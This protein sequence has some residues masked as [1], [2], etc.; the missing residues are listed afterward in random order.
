MTYKGIVTALVTPMKEDGSLDEKGFRNL[1]QFQMNKNIDGILIL[2]GTGEYLALSDTQRRRAIAIAVNEVD[3][4]VPLYVGLLSPGIN[5]NIQIGKYAKDAGVDAVMVITPYYLS[6]TQEGMMDYYRQI[7]QA[8]DM[9][10]LLYNYP[11]KTGVNIAPETVEKL[12]DEIPNMIGI[13]ECTYHTGHVID[14]IKRVGSKITVFAGEEYSALPTMILGA[15]GAI[16]ASS[17]IIPEFWLKLQ[18][19]VENKQIDEAV[20]LNEQYYSVFKA[21]F[22]ESNPGPLKYAL[23]KMHLIDQAVG[24]PLLNVSDETKAHMDQVMREF[25]I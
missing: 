23:H 16:M 21:I 20:K 14:L 17:N 25:G 3:G 9:P 5:D 11:S 2:G 19:L 13:K 24:T 4:N 7:N 8:L 18:Q 12:V 6:P 1:L 22:M 10:I 15:K